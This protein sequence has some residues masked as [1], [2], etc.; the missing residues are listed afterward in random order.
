ML[1]YITSGYTS[2]KNGSK[3]DG[4]VPYVT[5]QAIGHRETC[6][7][8]TLAF[9]TR[10]GRDLLPYG[11]HAG[12][13]D[14]LRAVENSSAFFAVKGR[15]KIFPHRDSHDYFII[16]LFA[17]LWEVILYSP[18]GRRQRKFEFPSNAIY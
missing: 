7:K 14:I 15:C 2:Y 18:P 6:L 11:R 10:L 16:S 13:I 4:D 17:S 8:D 3:F 9:I 5:T 12:S 1:T